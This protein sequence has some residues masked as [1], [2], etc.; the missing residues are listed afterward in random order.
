MARPV[1]WPTEEK[2]RENIKW[3]QQLFKRGNA[4]IALTSEEAEQFVSTLGVILSLYNSSMS[5]P[6]DPEKKLLLNTAEKTQIE[7]YRD[8]VEKE[9]LRRIRCRPPR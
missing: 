6:D 2:D 7:T 3:L 5:D 4:E 8:A 9:G 1:E